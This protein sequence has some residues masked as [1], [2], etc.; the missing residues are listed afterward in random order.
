MCPKCEIVEM[1]VEKRE[2]NQ[3]YL[4]CKKCGEETTIN[5]EDLEQSVNQDE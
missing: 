4:K 3:L 1:R 5:I 2:E